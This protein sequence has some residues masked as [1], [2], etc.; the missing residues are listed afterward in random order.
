MSSLVRALC[1]AAPVALFAGCAEDKEAYDL[2]AWQSPLASQFSGTP[3]AAEGERIYR[4][5]Q[6]ND[7]SDY[8]FRCTSCHG[9]DP[10]DTLTEDADALSRPAHTTWNAPHRERW[11]IGQSWDEKQSDILGAYGG[12]VCIRAYYPDGAAMSAEQAAH[13]EAWMKTRID[14]SAGAPTSEPLDYFFTEWPTQSDFLASV[15]DGSGGYLYGADLG[16]VDAG[17]EL[18]QAHCGSCHSPDGASE[19]LIYTAAT[20]SLGELIA[21]IRKVDLDDGTEAPNDRMPRVPHDRLDD[22]E[23]ADLLAWLTQDRATG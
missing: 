23:L 17:A 2:D 13:L 18:A 14:S 6:W 19:P 20:A 12:Q 5:E 22:D 11:K 16:D 7:S 3:D 1:L 15:S 21:R 10:G 4:E 9:N 8:A